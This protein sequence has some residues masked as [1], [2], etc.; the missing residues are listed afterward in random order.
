MRHITR[1]HTACVYASKKSVEEILTI[2]SNKG[3]ERWLC[4]YLQLSQRFV[5]REF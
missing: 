2:A 1:Y 3:T 5:S 4:Y